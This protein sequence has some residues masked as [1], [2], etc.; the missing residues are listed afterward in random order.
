ME[1]TEAAIRGMLN[2]GID[3]ACISTMLRCTFRL[4]QEAKAAI[5]AEAMIEARQRA[6]VAMR[7]P[8]PALEDKRAFNEKAKA[9]RKRMRE[10][11]KQG[12]KSPPSGIREC[13]VVEPES[14]TY[15]EM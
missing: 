13:H 1:R 11:T 12:G 8:S 3:I 7:T 6:A 10:H 5:E 15:R 4:V 14:E 9:M 2:E